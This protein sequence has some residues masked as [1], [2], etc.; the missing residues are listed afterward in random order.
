MS[1]RKSTNWKLEITK[2]AE[3]QFAGLPHV[4]QKRI[5]EAFDILTT[6]PYSGKKLRGKYEG[7]YRLTVGDF[8]LLY[9]IEN[10]R[11]TVVVIK[12]VDRK[13]AYKLPP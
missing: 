6:N 9:T 13:D 1:L 7:F 12:I 5:V 2:K 11:V 10:E 3:K 4:I 8:R